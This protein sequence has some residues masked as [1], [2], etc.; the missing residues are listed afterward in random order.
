MAKI[1]EID[2]QGGAVGAKVA[3]NRVKVLVFLMG[4]NENGWM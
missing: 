2:H 3:K 1:P 4:E